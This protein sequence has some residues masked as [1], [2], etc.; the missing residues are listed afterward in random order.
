L[1][2]V[3]EWNRSTVEV[4]HQVVP[5]KRLKTLEVSDV[6]AELLAGGQQEMKFNYGRPMG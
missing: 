6:K 4:T 2:C 1:Q 3:E 5:T